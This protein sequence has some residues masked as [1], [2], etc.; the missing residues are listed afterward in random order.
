MKIFDKLFRRKKAQEEEFLQEGLEQSE[1]QEI[2]L[3]REDIDVF[4]DIQRKQFV[5]SCLDR[6]RRQLVK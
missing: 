4:D 2:S 5:E 3:D 1:E 6:W